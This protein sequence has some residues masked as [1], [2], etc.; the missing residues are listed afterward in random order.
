MMKPKS[1]KKIRRS[2]LNVPRGTRR[3]TMWSI[4]RECIDKRKNP[5]IQSLSQ[6]WSIPLPMLSPT[7]GSTLKMMSIHSIGSM[8][9]SVCLNMCLTIKQRISW[10]YTCKVRLAHGTLLAWFLSWKKHELNK[11][12]IPFSLFSPQSTIQLLSIPKRDGKLIHQVRK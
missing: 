5:R 6:R 1:W 9:I 12:W 10:F 8:E 11:V 7:G 3:S 4:T 2:R